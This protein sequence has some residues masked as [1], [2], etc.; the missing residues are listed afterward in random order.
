M[1][2]KNDVFLELSSTKDLDRFQ[3]NTSS[4]FI[5]YLDEGLI[6]DSDLF[7]IGLSQVS[8]CLDKPEIDITPTTDQPKPQE[9]LFDDTGTENL[10]TIWSKLETQFKIKN[11]GRNV[12][13]LFVRLN[14]GF[15]VFKAPIELYLVNLVGE[16]TIRVK[17]V[18][19]ADGRELHIPKHLSEILG[20]DSEVFQVG[21]SIAQHEMNNVKFLRVSKEELYQFSLI[22]WEPTT[23]AMEEPDTKELDDVAFSIAMALR[24][25]GR[26]ESI[27]AASESGRLVITFYQPNFKLQLPPVVN[28]YLDIDEKY[29][30]YEKETR[31]KPTPIVHNENVPRNI[32]SSSLT[33]SVHILCDAVE[34]QRVG[35][36]YYPI[37]RLILRPSN[38][39]NNYDFNPVFYMK[40][41]R[42]ELRCI[43][44]RI[45]D[46]NFVSIKPSDTETIAVLHLKKAVP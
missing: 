45:L 17:L 19:K 42:E 1:E 14:D 36:S 44:I 12:K 15:R 7:Q 10:I 23:V 24:N 39:E 6:L 43:R 13:E 33:K 22:S 40:P 34:N 8:F 32:D 31:I 30:F 46:S 27:G 18:F 20:F 41:R 3:N 2:L 28:K 35:S 38:N 26:L 9:R 11:D 4:D 16:K 5:N 25:A 29:V 37:L 21:E